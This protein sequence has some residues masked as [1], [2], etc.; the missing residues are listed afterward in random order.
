MRETTTK[1]LLKH[2]SDFRLKSNGNLLVMKN[3]TAMSLSEDGGDLLKFVS[4]VTCLPF[5]FPSVPQLNKFNNSHYGLVL[6]NR[7]PVANGIA[8]RLRGG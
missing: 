8:L 1:L 4:H 6:I 5:T 2:L 7:N 3:Y